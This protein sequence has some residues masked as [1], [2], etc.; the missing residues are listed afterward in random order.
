MDCLHHLEICD[1]CGGL[2]MTTLTRI[3]GVLSISI[4]GGPALPVFEAFTGPAR[5]ACSDTPAT[6]ES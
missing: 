5:S 6:E 2:D 1:E 4:D 3:P